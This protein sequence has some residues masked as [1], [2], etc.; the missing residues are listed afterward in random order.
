[1]GVLSQHS[2]HT[3]GDLLRIQ[4]ESRTNVCAKRSSADLLEELADLGF[5][6]TS[7]A[8]LVGVSIPAVRKWRHGATT[9]G[10]NRRRLA[11][12][13][14]LV[15]VLER[16][17]LIDDVASWLDVPLAGSALTGIDV[18]ADGGADDARPGGAGSGL[19]GIGVPADGHYHHLMAF[20]AGHIKDSQLLDWA[21][22]E[23]RDTVDDRFEVYRAGDDERAIRAGDDER[24]IRVRSEDED[25]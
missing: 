11:R 6:W 5:S 19:A 12:L 7:I 10:E 20:A 8:R 13:V 23:W 1:M 2:V 16:D 21:L 14:A 9:S 3:H 15:D 4:L 24:A 25:G 22:P 17:H 18:L